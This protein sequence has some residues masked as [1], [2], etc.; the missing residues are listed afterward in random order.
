MSYRLLVRTALKLHNLS[1][2]IVGRF[3]Q[4]LESDS[5]HPKHRLMRYHDWFVSKLK[6]EWHVLDIGCGNGA[7]AYDLIDACSSV[8]AIDINEKNIDR[9]QRE[10]SRR[11]ITYICGDAT[12]FSF[13]VN[14]DAIVISNVLEHIEDRVTFLKHIYA[15]QSVDNP[16]ILLLRVPMITRDWITLY[17][18]EMGVEWR[19]DKTHFTE[20]TVDQ[21]ETEL[22]QAG[23]HIEEC[24]VQFGEIYGIFKKNGSS[25]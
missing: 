2:R 4:K 15:N 6:S 14:Y 7:L 11:G 17:K 20:Y 16:P 21:L 23:L 10:H 22:L 3:S 5:L 24:C 18:Q 8:L 12:V 19:L 13:P 9:A 1:Y 25:E